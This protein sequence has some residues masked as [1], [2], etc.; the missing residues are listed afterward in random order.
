[1]APL[2]CLAD[3]RC[4]P[5]LLPFAH[6]LQLRRYPAK[7]IYEPWKAPLAVQKECGC[8]VGAD[9][10]VRIVDHDVAS[11]ANMGRLKEAYARGKEAAQSAEAARGFQPSAKK[12]KK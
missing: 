5:L 8:M 11:K 7:Y 4:D 3:G 6:S 2:H 12:A 1:M 9:Y 10:P